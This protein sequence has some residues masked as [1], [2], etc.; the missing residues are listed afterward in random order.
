L[1]N[2]GRDAND[3]KAMRLAVGRERKLWLSTKLV[4]A[5]MER[6]AHWGWPNTYTYTKSLG[7][8]GLTGTANLPYPPG[9][10][11]ILASALRYPFPGW[12]EGFTT[13]APLSYA[14][15]KGQRSIPAGEKTI[16]DMIPVDMVAG[17]LIAITAQALRVSERRVYQ[18]ASGDTN[19]FMASRSVE[20]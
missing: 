17:S 8:Q 2:E 19:P 18:M 16:L 1:T 9:R 11:S 5:G 20:L 15:M 6:A 10:A 13:S 3:E 7:E 4:E 14:V 12:N